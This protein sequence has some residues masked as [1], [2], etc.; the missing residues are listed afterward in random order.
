MSFKS[1]EFDSPLQAGSGKNMKQSTLQKLDKARAIYND[2]ITVTSGYRVHA[3][4]LRLKQQGY[5]VSKTSSHFKGYAVDIRPTSGL[6]AL[7]D[8]QG[9]LTVEQKRNE[10]TIQ[11]N[12]WKKFFQ[13]LWDAGF[14]RFGIMRNTIHVD[15]DPDK[16]TPVMW[17][18]NNTDTKTFKHVKLWFDENLK[19]EKSLKTIK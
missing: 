15:D 2:R 19:K 14:R 1:H 5:Q 16:F 6:I 4:Y 10:E 18:Y 9:K 17:T 11:L 12:K 13:S 3:D 7:S 8:I